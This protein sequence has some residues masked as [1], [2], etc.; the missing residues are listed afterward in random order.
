MSQALPP[1][2]PTGEEKP[3][4]RSS[5]SNNTRT[6]SAS[7]AP[8]TAGG[9]QRFSDLVVQDTSAR[10]RR[11]ESSAQGNRPGNSVNPSFSSPERAPELKRRCSQRKI[12]VGQSQTERSSQAIL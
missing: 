1:S 10:Q 11:R 9:A 5:K 6:S 12:D 4:S 3:G 7:C 8:L 2:A